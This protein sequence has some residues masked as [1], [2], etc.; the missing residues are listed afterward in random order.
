MITALG[1]CRVYLLF[2]FSETSPH[3]LFY[4][5]V[6]AQYVNAKMVTPLNGIVNKAG[7][8]AVYPKGLFDH[9]AIVHVLSVYL[10]CA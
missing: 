2:Y 10:Y 9:I 8:S 3:F 4:T 7:S 1:R 5:R 6:L